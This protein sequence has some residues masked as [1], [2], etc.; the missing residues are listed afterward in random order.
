MEITQ[1]DGANASVLPLFNTASLVGFGAV[2]ASLP[3]FKLIRDLV[4]GIAPSNPLISLSVAVNILAGITGSASGGMNIAL[5][6]LG[7]RYLELSQSAGISPEL[8][9]RVTS[10]ATG[11]PGCIASKWRGHNPVNH[12]QVDTPTILR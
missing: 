5:Q 2:I 1:D 10:I 12:L 4:L 6:T 8:M 11:G 3:A 7:D 9:H